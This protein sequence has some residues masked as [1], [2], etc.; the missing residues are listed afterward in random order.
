VRI[1]LAENRDALSI[2]SSSLHQQKL[3]FLPLVAGAMMIW[4]SISPW[5]QDPLGSLT[6]AWQLPVDPGWQIQAPALTYGLLCAASA[7]GCWFL[8]IARYLPFVNRLGL[9]QL[10]YKALICL[11]PA[12]LFSGQMLCCDF[13]RI[14]HMAQHE[15]QALLIHRL[16]LYSTVDQLILLRPFV[17]HV[18]T[19]WGRLQILIDQL[20]YGFLFPLLAFCLLAIWENFGSRTTGLRS[21]KSAFLLP[22]SII[23]LPGLI[24]ARASIGAVYEKQ[25]QSALSAGAYEQAL[26][27]LDTARFFLPTLNDAAFYHLERGQALYYLSPQQRTTLESRAYLAASYR[28]L[29]DFPDAFQQDYALWVDFPSTPWIVDELSGTLEVWIESQQPLKLGAGQTLDNAEASL[30]WIQML[31]RVDSTNV[32]GWYLEGRIYYMSHA[33]S[34]CISLLSRIPRLSQEAAILS[35][36]YTYLALSEMALGDPV[37]GRAWLFHAIALDAGYRNNT[38]RETLSGLH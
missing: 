36:V 13:A 6:T 15:Q 22:L 32:Y 29:R 7:I 27:L 9:P 1:T 35:S 3:L 21:K 5:L 31:E 4:A 25:A 38:A 33:Y 19:F 8:V 34:A 20:D 37:T 26:S 17:L 28:A 24:F 16:F 12:L 2:G 10:R 30:P 14:T 11:V 23:L 18:S